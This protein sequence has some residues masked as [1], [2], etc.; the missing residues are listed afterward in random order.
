MLT[1]TRRAGRAA[2]ARRAL[3]GTAAGACVALLTA[4]PA[5]ARME[6]P[7]DTGDQAAHAEMAA[8]AFPTRVTRTRVAGLYGVKVDGGWLLR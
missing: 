1:N 3:V 2:A 4:G 5:S 7:Q 8:A 6:A